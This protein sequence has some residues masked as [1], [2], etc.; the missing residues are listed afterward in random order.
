MDG[1]MLAISG[2]YVRL[3]GTDALDFRLFGS[4]GRH[5]VLMQN[6]HDGD[7]DS[8]GRYQR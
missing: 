8:I 5:R 7:P 2:K 1:N 6:D 4:A 3:R